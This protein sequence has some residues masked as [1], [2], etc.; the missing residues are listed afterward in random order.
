[1]CALVQAE[2]RKARYEIS[3]LPLLMHFTHCPAALLTLQPSVSSAEM[4]KAPKTKLHGG[5]G[6]T[7][8][9][10]HKGTWNAVTSDLASQ[11]NSKCLC[12]DG[13]SSFSN[14]PQ[15][16]SI[17]TGTLAKSRNTQSKAFCNISFLVNR[18]NRRFKP[19]ELKYMLFK[20]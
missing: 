14:S 8:I 13:Q 3:H 11:L 1:M 17:L 7:G 10:A 4:A 15:Q 18:F 12:R 9:N 2:N 6:V 19:Q 16:D 20:T 5:G